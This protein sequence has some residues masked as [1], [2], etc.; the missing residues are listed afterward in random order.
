M[1]QVAIGLG[2]NLGD[3]EQTLNRAVA[4]LQEF[5]G[6]IVLSSMYETDPMYVED[7]PKFL[8]MVVLG[9]T[10]SGP[11]ALF[12]AVKSLERKLG[13]THTFTNGPRVIDIDILGYGALRYDFEFED[14]T[15]FV[16]P[17]PRMEGRP[18]VWVPLREVEKALEIGLLRRELAINTSVAGVHKLNSH[19]GV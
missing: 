15:N 11:L 13:R 18:F 1:T 6:D 7:Q 19:A 5:L 14:E 3:R 2:T 12:H 9:R 4:G 10:N 16:I 8:N 17:H